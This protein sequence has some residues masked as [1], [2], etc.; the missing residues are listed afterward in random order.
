MPVRL[1][2]LRALQR[3]ALTP[4][5]WGMRQVRLLRLVPRLVHG[6][7]VLHRPPPR[8]PRPR[9]RAGLRRDRPGRG[10]IAPGRQPGPPPDKPATPTAGDAHH[11]PASPW[12]T[13]PHRP[14]GP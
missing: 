3:V 10:A 11:A 9:V 1:A 13:S 6:R 7:E 14:P 2:D 8:R 5:R 4:D 12:A